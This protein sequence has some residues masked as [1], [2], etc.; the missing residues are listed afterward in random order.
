M[1]RLRPLA[2]MRCVA[3]G[4]NSQKER[5]RV[6]VPWRG[7]VVSHQ[8]QLTG[9]NELRLRPLAGMRCVGNSS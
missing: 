5:G 8:I 4:K 9:R 1:I 2:G 6:S 3:S 7:C